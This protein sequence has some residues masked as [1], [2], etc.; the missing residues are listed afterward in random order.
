MAKYRSKVVTIDAIKWTGDKLEM[1]K[2]LGDERNGE[3]Q[4]DSLQPTVLTI[5]TREGAMRC[6]IGDWLIR[7][8][9]GEYYPC[10]DSVFQAQY[11]PAGIVHPEYPHAEVGQS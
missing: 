6:Q 4:P 10:K 8:L 5:R 7:G 2:F 1:M 3:V 11:E 9:E